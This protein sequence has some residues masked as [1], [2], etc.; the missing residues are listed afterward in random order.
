MIDIKYLKA[1][2]CFNFSEYGNNSI[3]FKV[4]DNIDYCKVAPCQYFTLL[5]EI[6]ETVFYTPWGAKPFPFSMEVLKSTDDSNIIQIITVDG[7]WRRQQF[8]NS[9]E[10]W[11]GEWININKVVDVIYNAD[12][13]IQKNLVD[14]WDIYMIIDESNP[15][16]RRWAG[17][18][19]TIEKIIE[20]IKTGTAKIY[21]N[22][23]LKIN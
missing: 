14:S 17:S 5:P 6:A 19:T 12:E 11:W 10:T 3:E 9:L 4:D 13:N 16:N 1:I 20:E 7:E 21:L 18:V 8:K 2:C 15:K 23:L 22:K